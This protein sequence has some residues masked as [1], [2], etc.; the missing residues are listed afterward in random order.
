ML[1]GFY[2]N[3][4]LSSKIASRPGV[5]TVDALDT[6]STTPTLTQ[7]QPY[8]LVVIA[9]SG[10]YANRVQMGNV[11]ADYVDGGGVVVHTAFEN[12]TFSYLQGRWLSGNYSPLVENVQGFTQPDYLGVYSTT[13]PLMQGVGGLLAENKVQAVLTSGSVEVAR[14]H[15]NS[16]LTMIAY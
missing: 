13:H 15:T 1:Q 2:P 14:Y 6:Y 7:L 5:A 10:N 4:S 12:V 8:D 11:L 16:S 9:G 3:T